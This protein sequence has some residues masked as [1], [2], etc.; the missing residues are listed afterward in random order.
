M[1]SI[2]NCSDEVQ[3]QEMLGQ[4]LT[5]LD[6]YIKSGVNELRFFNLYSLIEEQVFFHLSSGFMVNQITNT[7]QETYLMGSHN[8]SASDVDH[9]VEL[10]KQGKFGSLGKISR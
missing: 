6:S 7:A 10:Y 1:Q 5:F 2:C 8:C 4:V 3:K 9:Q